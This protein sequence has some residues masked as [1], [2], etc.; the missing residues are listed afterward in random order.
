MLSALLES[1]GRIVSENRVP[2]E[3]LLL[4]LDRIEGSEPPSNT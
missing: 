4:A 1:G 3:D 2:V